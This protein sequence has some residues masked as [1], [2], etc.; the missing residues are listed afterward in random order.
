MQITNM[1]IEMFG[2]SYNISDDLTIEDDA[3]IDRLAGQLRLMDPA[4]RLDPA[5]RIVQSVS[6]YHD[7]LLPLVSTCVLTLLSLFISSRF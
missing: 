6:V 7:H 1:N 4:E 3:K 2:S 5:Y